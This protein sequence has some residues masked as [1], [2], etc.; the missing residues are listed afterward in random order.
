MK[1]TFFLLCAI[2]WVPGAGL[3]PAQVAQPPRISVNSF[4]KVKARPDLAIIF[5]TVHTT[6]P[7]AA[8]ALDQNNRRVQAIKERLAALGYKEDQVKFSGNWFAPAGGRTVAYGDQR[9]TGFDVSVNLLIYIDGPELKDSQQFNSRV[10]GLLD[11]MSK[12]GASAGNMPIYPFSPGTTSIVAFTLKDPSAL[13]KQAFQQAWE[14]ARPMA[15]D[16]ARD[17]NVKITGIESVS[18][19][20]QQN[21][22]A[23][24][25]DSFGIDLPYKYLSSSVNEVSVRVNLYVQYY[26]K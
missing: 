3:L 11:E 13:E 26:Y 18:A 12:L 6:A 2:L 14:K 17:M 4:A 25:L 8:D 7:L 24:R 21:P 23:D 19:G 10:S 15:E 20:Q 1:K 9:P 5:L 16:I 22:N